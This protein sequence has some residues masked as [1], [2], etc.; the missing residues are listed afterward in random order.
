M[1]VQAESLAN[2]LAHG[3]HVYKGVK[4]LLYDA[5]MARSAEAQ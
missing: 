4:R 3:P 5:D 2:E 1:V